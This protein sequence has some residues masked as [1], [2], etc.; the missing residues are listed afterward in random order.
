MLSMT[1]C[2]EIFTV[3]KLIDSTMEIEMTLEQKRMLRQLY[4]V[5]RAQQKFEDGE[6][7]VES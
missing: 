3:D 6:I 1:G 2:D 7:G 5:R 4:N